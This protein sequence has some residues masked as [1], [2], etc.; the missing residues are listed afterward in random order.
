MLY[1]SKTRM[2]Y[3]TGSSVTSQGHKW[4][5]CAMNYLKKYVKSPIIE[6]SHYI[7]YPN[8]HLSDT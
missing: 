5:V 7:Y 3:M 2:S 6:F 1:I 4:A 8:E